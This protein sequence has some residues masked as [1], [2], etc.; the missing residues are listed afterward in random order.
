[1]TYSGVGQS[2]GSPTSWLAFRPRW[3]DR[4]VAVSKTGLAGRSLA[5]TAVTRTCRP[6]ARSVVSIGAVARRHRML[7]FGWSCRTT[8]CRTP[9][10]STTRLAAWSL[11]T[12]ARLASPGALTTS[13][14]YSSVTGSWR[15]SIAKPPS[16]AVTGWTVSGFVRVP[17]VA[18]GPTGCPVTTSYARN[19]ER[20]VIELADVCGLV[21][22]PDGEAAPMTATSR[23]LGEVVAAA[24]DL[25]CRSI[26]LGIGGSSS[27]DGGAGMAQ[28]LG[29]VLTDADGALIGPGGGALADVAG[30][31]LAPLRRRL[32]GIEILVASDV[33]NPLTGPHG[34]AAVCGPQKGA[35]PDQVRI[36]DATLRHFADVVGV[37][38]GR[39][40][41]DTPGSGA[42]GGVGFAAIALLGARLGTGIDV[43]LDMVGFEERLSDAALVI[44]GEGSLDEQTLR[45]KAPVGVA[46]A[47][48]RAGVPVVAVCGRK[49]LSD[50]ALA[51]AGIS[52]AYAL[53]DLEPDPSRSMAAA[54]ELLER[55]G[56]QITTDLWPAPTA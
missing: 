13:C 33:D 49:L 35:T 45:G 37:A 20:A 46:A 2:I 6:G 32:A 4:Q 36:L 28:A 21:R 29:A 42:A 5:D 34:A 3:S 53:S 11:P 51:E 26:V 7:V 16:I 47:A 9:V 1:M 48:A 25:G 22:L 10:G 8:A 17:V 31:D 43:L 55:L 23:G 12:S 18:S 56:A 30:I 50:A 52:R 38:T 14:S 41:Q 54:P 39:D 27:T 15:Y 40:E 44:T 19:G 24:I